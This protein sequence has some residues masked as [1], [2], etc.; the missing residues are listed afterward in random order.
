MLKQDAAPVFGE[1]EPVDV[2]EDVQDLLDAVT[3][4]DLRKLEQ[5]LQHLSSGASRGRSVEELV[6]EP[7]DAEGTT[8]L[9][10]ACQLGHES[11]VTRLIAAGAD[12]N[13]VACGDSTREKKTAVN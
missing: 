3:E 8:L 4:C 5:S 12:I 9:W 7:F 13:G 11:I 2:D 10:Q 1:V 6:N